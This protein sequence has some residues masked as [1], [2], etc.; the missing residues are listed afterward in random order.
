MKLLRLILKEILIMRNMFL[1]GENIRDIKSACHF[2]Y[3]DYL[4]DKKDIENATIHYN[5]AINLNPKN[6]YAYWGLTASLI[7]KGLFIEAMESCDKGISVKSDSRFFIL[8][9]II[10]TALGKPDIAEEARLKTLKYFNNKLDVAYDALGYM[11]Y[12][13]NMLDRAEHYLKEALAANPGEAGI[14]YNLAIIYSKKHQHQM[15]KEEFQKVLELSSSN[16]SKEN[17]YKKYA[18]KALKNVNI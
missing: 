17:R 13:F 10:Y 3:A 2:E 6:Y 18:E 9:S 1:T 8:Q 14:H 4:Y 7:A 12:R 15:A 11:Y 16:R 5:K